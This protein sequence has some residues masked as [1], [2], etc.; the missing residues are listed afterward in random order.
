MVGMG[1]VVSAVLGFSLSIILTKLGRDDRRLDRVRFISLVI[2]AIK[3]MLL[4]LAKLGL[5]HF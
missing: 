2:V 1:S 4:Y 5:M 3:T